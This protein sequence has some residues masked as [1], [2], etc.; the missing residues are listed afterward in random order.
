MR[1]VNFTG[2]KYVLQD[3]VTKRNKDYHVSKICE[4]KYDP[5]N[6]DPL[7]YAL[8]DE[9]NWYAVEKISHMRGDQTGLKRNLSFK[10]HWINEDK[11]SYE[12]WHVVR[13][14]RALQDFI[15]NHKK[16]EVRNLLPKNIEMESD[17]MMKYHQKSTTLRRIIHSIFPYFGVV[18]T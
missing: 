16:E 18:F 3:L 17:V 8:K 1:V 6:Q 9:I 4:F 11:P 5:I 7:Q 10:V 12:P 14:T 2:S 15:L 13:R